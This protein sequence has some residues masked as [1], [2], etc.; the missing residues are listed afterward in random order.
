[1]PS[2]I[3]TAPASVVVVVS[4]EQTADVG[5]AENEDKQDYPAAIVVVPKHKSYLQSLHMQMCFSPRRPLKN[6]ALHLHY[7]LKFEMCYC[8]QK[9]KEIFL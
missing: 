9:K 8:F 7:M 4:A 3:T 5:V 1:M 6:N 2:A